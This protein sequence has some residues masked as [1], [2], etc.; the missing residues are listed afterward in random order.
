MPFLSDLVLEDRKGYWRVH[1]PLRYHSKR[2]DVTWAVPIG[3]K[4]DLASVPRLFWRM[5]PRDGE[6]R[7]AAVVHDY[8]VRYPVPELHDGQP[9]TWGEAANVF[10]EAMKDLGIPAWRRWPLVAAVKL[11]GLWQ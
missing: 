5:F 9:I 11:A 4:T 10:D 3:F 1:K 6:Y 8:L 7:K 2:Y